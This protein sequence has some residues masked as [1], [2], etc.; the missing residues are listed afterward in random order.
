VT[1]PITRPGWF[2]IER[3]FGGGDRRAELRAGM[4]QTLERIRATAELDSSGAVDG[5]ATGDD[6]REA[7][8]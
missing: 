5:S 3:V 6:R 7:P 4:Q 2:V 8:S 1:R